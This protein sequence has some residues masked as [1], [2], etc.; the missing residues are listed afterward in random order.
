MVKR[1]KSLSNV[2]SE[3]SRG[4]LTT[5]IPILSKDNVRDLEEVFQVMV[6]HLRPMIFE[7]K[8]GLPPCPED[9]YAP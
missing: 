1:L 3:I 6:S 2:A 8:R 9:Q 7:M 5:D 4:K